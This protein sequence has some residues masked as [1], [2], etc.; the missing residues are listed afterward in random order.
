MTETPQS[1]DSVPPPAPFMTYER[2]VRQTITVAKVTAETV[3]QIAA[4]V[5]GSVD[6]SKGD[7]VLVV[8]PNNLDGSPWRV[9]VGWEV[10]LSGTR[11]MNA[12]GFNRD[13]DWLPVC[14]TPSPTGPEEGR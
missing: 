5:G 11:L 12:N 4:H 1:V 3:G 10:S 7:P 6:Y 2:T 8:P 13:G 9:K 14:T